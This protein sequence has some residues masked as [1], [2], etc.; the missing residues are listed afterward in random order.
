MSKWHNP[1]N[2]SWT[3]K[4]LNKLSKH[5]IHYEAEYITENQ[6]GFGCS[7]DQAINS[8]KGRNQVSSFIFIFLKEQ[9]NILSKEYLFIQHYVLLLK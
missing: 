9:M 1:H 5:L 2:Q 3:V 6:S 7:I 4:T 8:L